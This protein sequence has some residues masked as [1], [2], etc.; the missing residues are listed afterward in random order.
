MAHDHPFIIQAN[1]ARFR[2]LLQTE[3][4][5]PTLQIIRRLLAEFEAIIAALPRSRPSAPH[6]AF[7]AW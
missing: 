6:P 4:D 7:V 2:F 5:V 1:I 3:T